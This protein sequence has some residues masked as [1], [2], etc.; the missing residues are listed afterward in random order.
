M[1]IPN[2]CADIYG[3]C[4]D[5]WE[6]VALTTADCEAVYPDPPEPPLSLGGTNAVKTFPS[7][8]I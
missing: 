5:H 8:V 6:Q 1:Y 2:G 3:L 7:H 4:A